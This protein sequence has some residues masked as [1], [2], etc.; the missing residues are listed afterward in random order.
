M[1]VNSIGIN[2]LLKSPE[3]KL[4][5][6]GSF[7]DV[8]KKVLADLE[9]K[10]KAEGAP[11]SKKVIIIKRTDDGIVIDENG[12]NKGK[13]EDLTTLF[14]NSLLPPGTNEKKDDKN[15]SNLKESSAVTSENNIENDIKILE[16]MIGGTLEEKEN[17]VKTPSSQPWIAR[18]GY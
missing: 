11:I 6:K 3:F 2:F 10:E 5:A 4:V 12:N 9:N 14:F 18:G 8:L 7:S 13:R 16:V 17:F 1:E 15:D